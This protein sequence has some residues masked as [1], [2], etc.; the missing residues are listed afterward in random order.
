VRQALEKLTA[1]QM[2]DVHF[3]TT[4]GR[5]I[6]LSRYT[7]SEPD[8]KLLLERLKIALPPKSPPNITPAQAAAAT[9]VVQTFGAA[10]SIN[11]ALGYSLP[12]E[13]ATT[14]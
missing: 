9:P 2:L 1:I 12:L 6:T 4:D 3:P 11:Q 14:G 10:P 13:Y 8:L 7:Q 5:E